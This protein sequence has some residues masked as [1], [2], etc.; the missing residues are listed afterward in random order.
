MQAKLQNLMII[1]KTKQLGWKIRLKSF[2]L[3][4]LTWYIWIGMFFMVYQYQKNILNHPIINMFYI[5][6]VILM[7]FAVVCCLIFCT[8]CWSLIT[9]TKPKLA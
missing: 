2:F 9:K 7:M 1:N 8:V 5:G 4:I 6:E 3:S